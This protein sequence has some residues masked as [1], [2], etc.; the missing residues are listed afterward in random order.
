[1]GIEEN[2]L[3]KFRS[4]YGKDYTRIASEDLETGDFVRLCKRRIDLISVHE[5]KANN[6]PRQVFNF[7]QEPQRSEPIQLVE[8]KGI[9]GRLLRSGFF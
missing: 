8:E 4:Y 5:F 9:I 2:G 6:S 3:R 1:M 7:Q